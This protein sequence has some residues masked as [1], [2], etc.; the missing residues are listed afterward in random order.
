MTT[1]DKIRWGILGPGHI[2]RRMADALRRVSDAEILAV[3]SRELSRAQQFA[4]EFGVAR[5]YGSYHDLLADGDVDIVYVAT[6]HPFHAAD[7]VLALE[8][9]K[10]VL[11]EKP[12]AVNAAEAAEVIDLAKSKRVFLAEAM[13]TRWL[14]SIE[15]LRELLAA[16]AVGE[17]QLV[18]ADFSFQ[19]SGDP[20]G[21]L[22]NPDLAGGALLDVGCYCM[23]LASMILGQPEH[24]E[25]QARI[26]PTG[27]DE[28]TAILL[29]NAHR[30]MAVLTCAVRSVGPQEA[31]IIGRRGLIKL[32][33]AWWRGGRVVL[34]PA[35]GA[36]Q[37]FDIPQE[38]N[39]F[40]YEVREA[41][42]CLRAGETQTP[43]L[44]LDESLG[45]METMDRVR[46]QI[47]LTYPFEKQPLKVPIR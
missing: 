1:T 35:G 6:P 8:A 37:V 29:K 36:E 25:A 42:R 3:G 45:I 9:G 2:A 47:G 31:F 30:Q 41:H 5:A 39:G 27:V 20:T 26:G 11:C 23:S 21:R 12:L 43:A 14:P 44:P 15:K 13:W 19:G 46:Q 38:E 32:E 10:A 7:T 24:V 28:Q 34:R 18:Q 17:V 22:L 33:S 4:A 16:E 40:V